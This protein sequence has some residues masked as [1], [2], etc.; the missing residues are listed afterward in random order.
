MCLQLWHS[1]LFKDPSVWRNLILPELQASRCKA[2]WTSSCHSVYK[3]GPVTAG[4][5]KLIFP[6]MGVRESRNTFLIDQAPFF[7]LFW[8]RAQVMV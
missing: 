7:L 5:T 1:L 8:P 3:E 2:V 6:G 4:D